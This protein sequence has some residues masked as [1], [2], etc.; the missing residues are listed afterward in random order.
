MVKV[1]EKKG[2]GRK[3]EKKQRI[4]YS[5]DPVQ[6]YDVETFTCLLK[7]DLLGH[8]EFLN[9]N[10]DSSSHTYITLPHTQ[11]TEDT[12]GCRVIGSKRGSRDRSPDKKGLNWCKLV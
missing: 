10:L 6:K 9:F 3:R 12:R 11:R 4:S 1:K 8:Y 7:V 2:R 5:N